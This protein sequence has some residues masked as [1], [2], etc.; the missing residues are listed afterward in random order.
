MTR[1]LHWPVDVILEAGVN[2]EGNLSNALKMVD[3]A[4]SVC[5]KAIKFQT[6]SASKLAAKDS[7]AYWDT[8]KESTTSQFELFSKYDK[9]SAKDYSTISEKC[10]ERG[11]EFSTT[12]FD[13]D[14][15]DRLDHLVNFYKIA[16]ADLTNYPLIREMANRGKPILLSTGASTINEI[17]KTLEEI[18]KINNRAKVSLMHCVLNYPTEIK[19]AFLNRIQDL[20]S[21]FPGLKIGYSDHTMADNSQLSIG[22]AVALGAEIIETHFTF[23]KS[24][25]GNDHYHALDVD[26]VFQLNKTII[27]VK[28]MQEYSEEAFV[29]AQLSARNHARRGIYA[30]VE[31]KPGHII[32]PSD[33]IALRPITEG[34]IPVER[35]D[36]VVGRKMNR[37]ILQGEKLS[38]YFL[39]ND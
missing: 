21:N 36:E 33:L 10:I 30:A 24:L 23:D 38:F 15:L 4:A 22:I 18:Y 7:P 35:L 6:Y 25:K 2:H 13:L 9:F 39:S 29:G 31:M 8:S 11:I 27:N 1:D 26:D 17:K 28:S 32:K 12:F 37:E 34:G 16:S 19:N 3:L 14:W 5:V 20:K